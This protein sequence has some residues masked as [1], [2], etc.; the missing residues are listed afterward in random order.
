MNDSRKRLINGNQAIAAAAID[1]GCRYYFSYPITPQSEIPEYLSLH[2]PEVGG[3][4]LQAESEIASI[5]MV[6][7]ASA[8]G[9]RAM[10]SS[11]GPGISLKQEGLS[12]MAADELPALIVNI[13]RTGPGLGGIAASQGDY[14]QATKGGGH[15]D[16]RIIVL[17]PSSVQEMYDLTIKGFDLADTYRTPVMILADSVLGQ[18]KESVVMGGRKKS[19]PTKKDW[20]LT[21]CE[22]RSPSIIKSLY[23]DGDKSSEHNRKLFEKYQ[24]IQKNEVICELNRCKDADLILIAFGSAARIAKTSIETAREKGIKV[25][26]LRPITLFPFP[27]QQVRDISTNIKDILV[28]E[29]NTGQMVEDV[30]ISASENARVTFYGKPSGNVLEAEEIL[31]Q[32]ERCMNKVGT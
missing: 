10:T 32:I 12:Y 25:G 6:L 8:A 20:A 24:R 21:G 30:L 9:A 17:A 28:V 23:L 31:C 5:N 19:T 11:S 2:L 29:Q 14:F 27:N 7:G 4:F 1:A 15:G 16:Y 18:M 3:T 26:M 22:G 13:S